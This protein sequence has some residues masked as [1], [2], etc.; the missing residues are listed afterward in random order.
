M[1]LVREVLDNSYNL[2]YLSSGKRHTTNMPPAFVPYQKIRWRYIGLADGQ[3]SQERYALLRLCQVLG[4]H[5]AEIQSVI[6]P[7]MFLPGLDPVSAL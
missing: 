5:A 6:Y 3:P 1:W 7:D 4:S 2:S